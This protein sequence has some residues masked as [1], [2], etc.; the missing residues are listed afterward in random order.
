LSQKTRMEALITLIIVATSLGI[1]LL[2]LTA[3]TARAQEGI[4]TTGR[5]IECSRQGAVGAVLR[6]AAVCNVRFRLPS[7]YN[8]LVARRKDNGATLARVDAP[9]LGAQVLL[10]IPMPTITF[11]LDPNPLEGEIVAFYPRPSDP[12]VIL[13]SNAAPFVETLPIDFV[14]P[15]LTIPEL[16]E[17]FMQLAPAGLPSVP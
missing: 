7:G 10:A 6:R 11:P 14:I 17:A 3:Q 5:K 2:V 15:A 12:N 13:P 8:S 16:L 9:E 4:V 1:F